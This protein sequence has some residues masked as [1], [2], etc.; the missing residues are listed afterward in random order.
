[1][2]AKPLQELVQCRLA[3]RGLKS[4]RRREAILKAFFGAREHFTVDELYERAKMLD[5]KVGYTTV[6]R[7]LKL[8]AETGFAAPQKFHDGFIRYER[9]IEERH[10]DHLICIGCGNVEEFTDAR[11]EKI[12]ETIALSRR[13]AMTHH[14]M[15]LYGYC[16]ACDARRATRRKG[17]R[18]G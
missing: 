1:M 9:V 14:R 16:R 4:S 12:Q 8:L 6:W 18:N 13:F 3:E 17:R 2:K 10:H 15:E 7:T 5:P 11:I